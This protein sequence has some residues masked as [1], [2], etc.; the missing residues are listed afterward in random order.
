MEPD[1]QWTHC[2]IHRKALAVKKMPKELKFVLDSA[3]KTVNFISPDRC[4]LIYSRS[5]VM[6]WAASM[7]NSCFIQK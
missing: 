5:S 1:V 4:I 3:V 6:R 7:S 2:S